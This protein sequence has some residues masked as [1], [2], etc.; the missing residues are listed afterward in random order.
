[1]DHH[2][3]AAVTDALRRRGIDVLTAEEDGSR[4]LP[5][6]DLLTRA[7]NLGRVL[8]TQDQDLLVESCRRLRA[9]E[10]FGGVIY[11]KQRRLSDRQIIEELALI[12]DATDA[13]EWLNRLDYLPLK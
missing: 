10:K 1:M 3:R 9:G 4:R 7:T 8:F 2:V 13:A 6:P 12:A 11:V 5:D